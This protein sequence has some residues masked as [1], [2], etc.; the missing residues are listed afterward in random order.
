MHS[1]GHPETTPPPT[2]V[3]V[4]ATTR[5]GTVSALREAGRLAQPDAQ[6]IA[7]LVPQVTSYADPEGAAP[8]DSVAL[9][10]DYAA[11]ASAIGISAVPY[12]CVCQRPRDIVQWFQVGGSTVVVGGRRGRWRLTKAQRLAQELTRLGLHVVFA[13]GV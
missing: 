7:L 4:V 8:T 2:T 13:D 6:R 9:M 12:V 5:E 1:E 10:K 11:L 3:Y